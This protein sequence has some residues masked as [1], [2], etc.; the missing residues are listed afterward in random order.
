MGL[1]FTRISDKPG[2]A[3]YILYS[4]NSVELRE[5]EKIKADVEALGDYQLVIIDVRTPDG[6]N[7]R[8]F[9]DFLPEQLPVAFIIR[10]DDSIAS[11]WI[12]QD[13]FPK[14]A[15]DIIYYLRQISE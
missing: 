1:D 5:Y 6:E 2:A 11:Q 15:N 9:Y 7:V 4:G 10:D 14:N 13:Q 12:G 8:D 3:M